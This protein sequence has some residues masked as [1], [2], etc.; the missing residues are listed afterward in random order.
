MAATHRASSER[1]LWML[2]KDR[3]QL[4]AFMTQRGLSVRELAHWSHCHP[5]TIGHL[6]TGHMKTCT[7]Q[8]AAR[9]EKALALEPGRLFEPKTLPSSSSVASNDRQGD[10]A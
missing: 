8:L 2:L 5:S 10:A 9:I 7:P 4:I 1:R 3:Y 6:R